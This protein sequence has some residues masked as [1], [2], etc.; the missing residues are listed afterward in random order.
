MALAGWES[1]VVDEKVQKVHAYDEADAKVWAAVALGL[2]LLAAIP[3]GG[4]S[5]LAGIAAAGATLGAAYSLNTLYEHYK[6][7]GLEV[8]EG[9]TDF[10]KARSHCSV[11]LKFD[12]V[13]VRLAHLGLELGRCRHGL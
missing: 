4:S 6:Q 11:I 12:L 13:G 8:A 3:T 1:R 2:G 9:A 10:D 7:Y 5:L